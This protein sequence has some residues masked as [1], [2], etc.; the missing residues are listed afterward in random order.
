MKNRIL[1]LAVVLASAALVGC[2]PF[3]FSQISGSGHVVTT[4]MAFSGFQSVE[5]GS[6][7]AVHIKSGDRFS[8]AIKTDDNLL[9]TISVTQDGSWL[10]LGVKSGNNISPTSL[11]AEIVMPKLEGLSASGAAKIDFPPFKM[12]KFTAEA[13]GASHINGTIDAKSAHVECSGASAVELLGNATD[14]DLSGSGASHLRCKGL[15][16]SQGTVD[17]SGASK[18]EVQATKHLDYSLSGASHLA[19]SG[20]PSIGRSESSGASSA[21]AE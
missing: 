12:D 9:D 6:A 20:Q 10:R 8:V 17:L 7:F 18:A 16:A 14:V 11:Q 2:G 3:S 21:H 13:S 19:Y 1:S 4:N 15:T 5:A